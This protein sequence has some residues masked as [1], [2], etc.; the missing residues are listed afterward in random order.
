MIVLT[1]QWIVQHPPGDLLYAIYG[2]EGGEEAKAP[3]DEDA[4][5]KKLNLPFDMT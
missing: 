1:L 5:R 2:V 4:I 3:F